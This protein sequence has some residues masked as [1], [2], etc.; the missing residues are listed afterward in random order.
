[1][2]VT[3]LTIGTQG[4]VR[5]FVALGAGLRRQG[6]AVRIATNRSFADLVTSAGLDFSPLTADFLEFMA[7]EPDAMARGLNPFIV[8][9]A[10]RRRLKEMASDWADEGRAA[11][12][13]ADLLI[14]NG[15]V[16]PL[17]ASLAEALG[18]PYVE[19]QLQPVTPCAEIPPMMLPPPRRPLPGVVNR[20][21]YHLLR[22]LTWQVLSPAFNGVVRRQLGLRGY[23]WVGPYYQQR[24]GRLGVLY[25]YSGNVVP[26]PAEWAPDVRV[27]GYWF[28][29]Q[30]E[31]WQ[32]P[33]ELSRFL[34]AGPKPIYIGF[35]SMLSGRAEAFTDLVIDAVRA[36]ERRAIIA[37]GWG[38]LVD[39]GAGDD[40][41]ILFVKQAPH[42]WLF[43]R[44]AMAVHHGGAGTTAAAVRAGIPSVVVPFFGDQ[45]FWAWRLEQL[46]V[47]PPRLDRKTLTAPALAA[48]IAAASTET[49]RGAARRLGEQ[50]RAEDGVG[51]ALRTL[52]EWGL[53]PPPLAASRPSLA[54]AG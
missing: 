2:R 42:D 41:R 39:R 51:A 50:V 14:G 10:A 45:P 17:A 21:L 38:G 29:D 33:A 6:H 31:A 9:S 52:A 49:M 19:S 26:R 25:G 20:S 12:H 5:P 18:K 27:A 48:A 53:E 1:M 28:L 4:D 40:D 36:S 30:A 46:G 44:V 16:A 15:M 37:T 34:D 43:P 35:G 32:P 24:P 11:C 23:P 47:A 8:L 7:S 54:A 3:I 22:V 13:D